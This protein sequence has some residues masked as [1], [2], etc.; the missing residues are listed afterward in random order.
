MDQQ[1]KHIFGILSKHF[2]KEYHV[3]GAIFKL[4]ADGTPVDFTPIDFD[5]QSIRDWW[6]PSVSRFT[7]KLD[8]FFTADKA[9]F[10]PISDTSAKLMIEALD[11]VRAQLQGHDNHYYYCSPSAEFDPKLERV[12]HDPIDYDGHPKPHLHDH[13]GSFQ[14]D[15]GSHPRAAT[16][17]K[18]FL[19]ETL[20]KVGGVPLEEMHATSEDGH[21]LNMPVV[22]T[23]MDLRD[24]IEA[25]SGN[26]GKMWNQRTEGR[27]VECEGGRNFYVYDSSSET[28][29][30]G[31]LK[32]LTVGQNK[33]PLTHI[34][35]H[36]S[37][38]WHHP[39]LH[40]GIAPSPTT[41]IHKPFQ[42]GR[43]AP[44]VAELK[45]EF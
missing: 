9:I 37:A 34:L 25:A 28:S 42:E 43:V 11:E 6:T 14:K 30:T 32:G 12:D 23:P 31:T 39:T 3:M 29:I 8:H 44:M 36:N 1:P 19:F 27:L 10:F 33:A 5:G 24:F 20:V 45:T 21:R 4:D 13:A 15:G 7:P 22:G 16:N 26:K 38:V 40:D 2:G 17:C 18:D 41:I 35:L